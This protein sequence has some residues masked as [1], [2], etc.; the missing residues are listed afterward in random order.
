MANSLF[1]LIDGSMFSICDELN[2]FE[3]SNFFCLIKKHF[4]S[5][6]KR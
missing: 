3:L 4:V 2:Y 5:N 1:H 6:N